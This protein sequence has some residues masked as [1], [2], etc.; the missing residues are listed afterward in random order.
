MKNYLRL[1]SF[2]KGHERLFTVATVLMIISAL[3]EGVQLTMLVPLTDIIF[4]KRQIVIPHEV[5]AFV[6]QF[7]TYLNQMNPEDLFWQLIVAVIILFLT[8]HVVSFW[9]GYFMNDISQEV[10]RD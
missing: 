8:K 4:N 7:L 3:F 9:H 1:L 6:S 5:P 2:L 10:M